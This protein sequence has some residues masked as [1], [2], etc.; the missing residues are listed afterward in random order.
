MEISV[1]FGAE[2]NAAADFVAMGVTVIVVVVV[3]EIGGAAT[4]A[5]QRH[6]HRPALTVNPLGGS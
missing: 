5:V 6:C 1:P 2:K 3:E 4:V